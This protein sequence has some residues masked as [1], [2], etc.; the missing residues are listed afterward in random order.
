MPN[1]YLR[2]PTSRCQFFRHRDPKHTLMNDEPLV[3]S[4][5]AHEMFIMRNSLINAPAK[6]NRIDMACFSQQQWCNML[7]GKHP[8]GGKA[9]VVRDEQS[10]LTYNEVQYLNGCKDIAKGVHEDY[11]CI[12]LPSEVEVVDTV[13]PVR[14]TFTLDTHGIR[15]LVLSLNNEFKRSLV[16]WALSTFDFCTSRGKIIAR[17]QNAMLERYLMRYGIESNEEE[18]D[19]LRRIIRRWFKTEHCNFHSYSCADMQYVDTRDKPQRIDD[20]QFM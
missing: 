1:I 3:F 2:L 8:A 16:E 6:S 20:V 7:V 13:Y 15:S 9:F 11:L 18:K 19:V 10:W 17:S 5:Y 14:P 12:R 4:N